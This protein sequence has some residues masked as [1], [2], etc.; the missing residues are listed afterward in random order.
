MTV[1][2]LVSWVVIVAT[3]LFVAVRAWKYAHTEDVGRA[4]EDISLKMAARYTVGYHQVFGWADNPQ[5]RENTTQ[6]SVGIASDAHSPVDQLRAIAVLGELEG[7]PAAIDQLDVIR[8]RLRSPRLSQDA[9][10]F[11][12]IYTRGPAALSAEHRQ[13]LID[14]HGW[15]ANLALSFGRP[16]TD[17]L[18]RSVIAAS[19]RAFWAAAG[20][21]ILL[22]GAGISGA[23]LFSLWL[24]RFIDRKIRTV[25]RP[26][27]S[28]SGT[29]LEAFALYLA[30]YVGIGWALSKFNH[31]PTW[32]PIA[33]DLLWV[34]FCCCWPIIRGVGWADLRQGLGWTR[35]RGIVR[36][37]GAGI[38]GYLAAFPLLALAIALTT[39]LGKLTGERALHPIMFG[40]GTGLKTVLGLYLLASV[41]APIVEETMFRGAL[42]HHLRFRHRWLFSAALSALIFASLHPQGWTAIPVL[43]GIG[44]TFAAIRE[45]RGTAVASAAAHALNNAVA[46]TLLILTLG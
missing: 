3:V 36:E 15:F 26:P 6:A 1:G 9:D 8:W 14:R 44:F 30:G 29:F 2:V 45:W 33:V 25:Y 42:F 31:R 11:R 5:T 32:L 28:P 7:G 22:A 40:A 37:M 4:A 21:F 10:S 35:G 43:G 18:R 19:L 13:Q 20:F 34:G 17:P 39:L 41:W 38:A 12:T 24:A 46:T 16:S 23:I 27:A